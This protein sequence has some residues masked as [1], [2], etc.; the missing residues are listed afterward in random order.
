V[1]VHR[2]RY[3]AVCVDV[4]ADVLGLWFVQFWSHFCSLLFLFSTRR[5]PAPRAGR[6]GAPRGA[7]RGA[8]RGR[9][10]RAPPAPRPTSPATRPA[11][12]AAGVAAHTRTSARRQATVCQNLARTEYV[13]G[14]LLNVHLHLCDELVSTPQHATHGGRRYLLG[15]DHRR[16]T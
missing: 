6:G 9:G 5:A 8:A 4:V 15:I 11:G 7:A 10:A 13:N 12:A 16:G 3:T 14:D 1:L 2:N